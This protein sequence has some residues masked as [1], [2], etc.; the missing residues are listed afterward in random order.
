MVQI[1]VIG[2]GY[3][4]KNLVRVFSDT[5]SATLHACCDADTTRLQ[6]I[7]Q[8]HPE[9]QRYTSVDALLQDDAVDAVAI[10]TPSPTHYAVA[11]SALEAGKHV[12]V[13]KPLTLQSQEAEHLISLSQKNDRRLMVGHLLLYHPAVTK[14]KDLVA[15]GDLGEIYYVYAQRLNL[16]IVR[17]EENAWWSLAPHDISVILHMFNQIPTGV[18]AR[19]EGY[20]RHDNQDVVFAN[21]QFPD[22]RM[23]Q[24]HVSWLDP[25]KMRK[26]TVVGSKKMVVFDDMEPTEKIRIYDKGVDI[27]IGYESYGDAITLRQGDIHIPRVDMEEPLKLECQHFIDCI[28]NNTVP[29]TDGVNGL[30]VVRILEAGQRSLENQ[31]AP[32]EVGEP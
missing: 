28:L 30:H 1:A 7:Q 8:A 17:Q 15:S 11:K 29:M 9:I 6:R 25:H 10:A 23:G 20:L 27:A 13:E 4:G 26:I 12:Y 18:S 24:I 31:G 5:K 19:G 21:L 16:G 22:R 2:T 32:V 14:L 3:W